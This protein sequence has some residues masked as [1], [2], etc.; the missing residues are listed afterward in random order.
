[1]PN[2]SKFP[3][4]R[5][6]SHTE[7]FNVAT[8]P[9][10]VANKGLLFN[11]FFEQYNP[12][13]K[14]YEE[15]RGT[16]SGKT[17]FLRRFVG[18]CGNNQQL[19]KQAIRQIQLANSQTGDFSVYQL[20]GHFVTGMGNSHPV[21]NGFLWHHT[22]GVPYLSGSMVKGLIR[23]LIEQYYQ[24]E[25]KADVLYQWF[26]SEDKKPKKNARDSQAGELIFFDAIPT[27]KPTL[28]MDIMTPHM[29]D[30]YAEGGKI[31]N[32]ETDS[33]KI[34]ADWHDPKP[35]PF[36]A[37]KNA[38]FLFSIAKR[39]ESNIE[40]KCVFECLDH[41]LTY[42]G[43]GAKTQT[44]YG[45]MLLNTRDT[46]NLKQLTRPKNIFTELE[47]DIKNH[48]WGVEGGKHKN[49]FYTD[50]AFQWIEKL[51]QYQDKSSDE[52]FSN[53]VKLL[54]CIIKLHYPNARNRTRDRQR[55]MWSRIQKL[56]QQV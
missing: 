35:I 42:L 18:G 26:G 7:Y 10:S 44:G 11:R 4:F 13:W 43:A 53:A 24:G 5:A 46:E 9:H 48:H 36:L 50:G 20:D 55:E 41:A 38:S 52:N 19:E 28:N 16:I 37:V 40:I 47:D 33:D 8:Q 29:G 3:L 54:F 22:L 1:M 31:T 15:G 27:A 34:P 12:S 2:E 23:A 39:A 45:Y 56:K 14:V 30:W 32:I 6:A 25:D 49:I 17:H 21:E 51:E